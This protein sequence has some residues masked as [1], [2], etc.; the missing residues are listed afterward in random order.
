M[1]VFSTTGSTIYQRRDKR[2]RKHSYPQGFTHERQVHS[3]FLFLEAKLKVV[4]ANSANNGAGL[5]RVGF[6]LVAGVCLLVVRAKV[7]LGM[8]AWPQLRGKVR[9]PSSCYQNPCKY[10]WWYD[11]MT[12]D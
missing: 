10:G 11:S 7:L 3:I 2:Q 5:T 1:S 4:L 9:R 8:P 6:A 12:C